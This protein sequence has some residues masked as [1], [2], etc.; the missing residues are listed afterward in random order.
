VTPTAR[1][2]SEDEKTLV[3]HF[4][5]ALKARGVNRVPRDWH[6]K[7][8]ATARAMLAGENAPSL[9]DWKAC[10]DW[11]L[12]KEPYWRDRVDH[13]ARV[14]ALWPRFVLQARRP[15]PGRGSHNEKERQIIREMIRKLY[16][17]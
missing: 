4:R 13:L 9:D 10:I 5:Q 17:N 15:G 14:E 12:T 16:E 2:Y 3:E 1:P 11:V 7:Q 8:L 6:L